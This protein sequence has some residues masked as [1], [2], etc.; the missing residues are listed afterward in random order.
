MTE[1]SLGPPPADPRM[2]PDMES[3]QW[4]TQLPD[5]PLFDPFGPPITDAMP[6][7]TEEPVV[8]VEKEEAPE[9]EFSF[10]PE[11]LVQF[12]TLLSVGEMSKYVDIFDSHIHIR[13]LNCDDELFISQFTKEYRE[14]DGYHRA[15]QLGVCAC[16]ILDING[17]PVTTF[18]TENPSRQEIFSKKVEELRKYRP[19]VIN[20]IYEQITELE[21]HFF[22]L[23]KHLGKLPG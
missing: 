21:V 6:S 13:T 14:T 3:P 7:P 5:D 8:V 11:E 2:D 1:A 17:Q 19:V 23:A 22:K 18:L 10:D 9:P 20:Q 15:Y 16:G 12:Q 4:S